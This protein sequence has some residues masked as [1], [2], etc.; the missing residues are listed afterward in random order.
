MVPPLPFAEPFVTGNASRGVCVASDLWDRGALLALRAGGLA[1]GGDTAARVGVTGVSGGGGISAMGGGGGMRLS[2]A[3]WGGEAGIVRAALAAE[4]DSRPLVKRSAATTASAA[5]MPPAANQAPRLDRTEESATSSTLVKYD[6]MGIRP[7]GRGAEA[8]RAGSAR[9]RGW[10]S[11]LAEA[12][13]SRTNAESTRVST[14]G[15]RLST[16]MDSGPAP[17]GAPNSSSSLGDHCAPPETRAS[18]NCQAGTYAEANRSA[19]SGLSVEAAGSSVSV[20][21]VV[22]CEA[23]SSA[24]SDIVHSPIKEREQM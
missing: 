9:T 10:R 4:G 18:S 12:G 22:S 5:A 14:T 11:V 1:T 24:E 15:A 19:S 17:G 3:V 8:A 2:S 23:S 16:R 13:S 6:G 7:T 20:D 21:V